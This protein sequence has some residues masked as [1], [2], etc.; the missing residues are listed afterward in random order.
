MG[1]SDSVSVR[2][3]RFSN[4]SLY[5][6]ETKYPSD[7]EVRLKQ[8]SKK[9]DGSVIFC[10]TNSPICVY[11]GWGELEKAK[12]RFDSHKEQ[13]E[14]SLKRMAK[15]KKHSR[16][17]VK[18]LAQRDF[19]VNGHDAHENHVKAITGDYHM[20]LPFFASGVEHEVRAVFLHC[21][22]SNRFFVFVA[23]GPPE[24]SQELAQVF[25]QVLDSMKCHII[26]YQPTLESSIRTPKRGL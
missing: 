23:D 4:F 22:D 3:L 10:P 13:A 5:D 21:K 12:L 7:W 18:L 6:I 14:D 16:M 19:V 15:E 17:G 1:S 8:G 26:E 24:D 25:Q 2:E 20:V 9:D 11:V